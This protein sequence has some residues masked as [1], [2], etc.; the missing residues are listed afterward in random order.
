MLTS[1]HFCEH[2]GKLGKYWQ[3][4]SSTLVVVH[5]LSYV[6]L[7]VIS[8]TAVCQAFLSFTVF[9]S[10]L[11]FMSIELMMPSNHLILCCPLLRLLSVFP[12]I[13][14]FSN[15][16]ALC[17]RWPK[18]WSFSFSLSPSNNIQDWF[19]LGLTGLISFIIDY[20]KC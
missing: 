1:P 7:F 4:V 19:P 2:I 15:E 5:L 8:W 17:I 10:L 16:L 13:K 14:V 6:W 12:S 9:W 3:D 11:K 20:A 18:Y